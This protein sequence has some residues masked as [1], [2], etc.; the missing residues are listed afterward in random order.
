MDNGYNGDFQLINSGSGT[1]F[2]VLYMTPG[3]N[4][5]FKYLATNAIGLE[6]SFSSV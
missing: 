1:T 2:T 3:L 5:R 4:Y 6:S